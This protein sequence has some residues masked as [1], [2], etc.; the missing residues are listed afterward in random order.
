MPQLDTATPVSNLL[1]AASAAAART[2]IGAAA[3]TDVTTVTAGLAAQVTKQATDLRDRDR[4]YGLNQARRGY[5][6]ASVNDLKPDFSSSTTMPSPRTSGVMV[7]SQSGYTVTAT[8]SGSSDAFAKSDI[9]RRIMWPDG[10]HAVIVDVPKNVTP[11]GDFTPILVATVDRPRTAAASTFSIQAKGVCHLGDGDSVGYSCLTDLRALLYRMCGY[12]GAFIAAASDASIGDYEGYVLSSGV[13]T[14][15]NAYDCAPAGQAWVVPVGESV[16][17]YINAK[18]DANLND[19]DQIFDIPQNERVTDCVTAIWKRKAGATLRIEAR[20]HEASA[21]NTSDWTL[22]ADNVDA[23]AGDEYLGWLE[24]NHAAGVCWHYRVTVLTDTGGGG[25]TLVGFYAENKAKPGAVFVSW[26][27]GGAKVTDFALIEN[28]ALKVLNWICRFD[29]H[30]YQSRDMGL[31]DGE[32]DGQ[33][34]DLEV[35]LTAYLA[36]WDTVCPRVDTVMWGGY[37]GYEGNVDHRIEVDIYRSIALARGYQFIDLM[38]LTATWAE[39]ESHGVNLDTIHTNRKGGRFQ[40][41]EGARQLGLFEYPFANMPSDV[42]SR[43]ADIDILRIQGRDVRLAI[44]AAKAGPWANGVKALSSS[45]YAAF[46]PVPAAGTAGFVVQLWFDVPSALPAATLALFGIYPAETTSSAAGFVT[47]TID[48]TGRLIFSF[49]NL[50][51]TGTATYRLVNWAQRYLGQRGCLTVIINTSLTYPIVYWGTERCNDVC[52][53]QYSATASVVLQRINE[54]FNLTGTF[55]N[56]GITQT[57]FARACAYWSGV[58]PATAELLKN[59]ERGYVGGVGATAPSAY[60]FASTGGGRYIRD[61]SGNGRHMLLG[62][63][64]FS[65]RH[66]P[67]DGSTTGYAWLVPA[68]VRTTHIM[69]ANS[70]GMVPL[71]GEDVVVNIG[72]GTL[73]TMTLPANPDT[74]AP[75]IHIIGMSAGGWKVSQL[76]GQQIVAGPGTT[77][78]SDSTSVGTAGYVQSASRYSTMRLKPLGSGLWAT[79]AFPAGAT[80]AASSSGNEASD[81]TVAR[82]AA[83]T[84]GG[85]R[86]SDTTYG[87]WATVPAI[88]TSGFTLQWW[89]QVPRTNPGTAVRLMHIASTKSVSALAGDLDVSFNTVGRLAVVGRTSGSTT[90]T[91][92]LLDGFIAA[93]A[94]QFVGI[95]VRFDPA[96]SFPEVFVDSSLSPLAWVLQSSGGP[97]MASVNYTG[98]NLLVGAD[99]GCYQFALW[100]GALSDAEVRENARAGRVTSVTTPLMY[101]PLTEGRGRTLRDYSGNGRDAVTH[102]PSGTDLDNAGN[103]W[104]TGN[105]WLRPDTVPAYATA[106]AST[107]SNIT[108]RQGATVVF[109]NN[110]GG[111]S[112]Q[113]ATTPDFVRMDGG[114]ITA[115][116]SGNAGYKINLRAGQTA[117]YVDPATGTKT[118]ST[119]GGSITSG[120]QGGDIVLFVENPGDGTTGVVLKIITGHFGMVIA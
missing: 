32:L 48:T 40:G 20:L 46:A 14:I 67:G 31:R 60:W 83:W 79:G 110:G 108:L 96:K 26:D 22:L 3:A 102:G 65:A 97:T 8:A 81:T 111:G 25:V 5:F 80:I 107:S 2:A 15:L 73:G 119:A 37:P 24:V 17:G 39:G 74:N 69:A 113:I 59:A 115:R 58:I 33:V 38:S 63:S 66:N 90:A 6:L 42:K 43:Y 50:L 103:G 112:R 106:V 10:S 118:T 98:T 78:G 62:A 84:R 93:Y 13:T 116:G 19:I 49:R 1:A 87:A 11:G 52:L 18:Y 88:A 120:A 12:G 76:A 70:L 45:G 91:S 100:S 86:Y 117:Y 114:L 35:Q 61:I 82:A 7:A 34:L 101:Y 85:F 51:N 30:H 57:H 71:P 16:E 56:L 29:L 28:S 104:T 95:T 9:G 109:T 77:V 4:M 68:G 54:P 75:E 36:K 23:G 72:D 94:G 89:G 99:T 41:T 55:F 53:P 44:E 47:A 105:I 64:S 27:T 92:W 21:L